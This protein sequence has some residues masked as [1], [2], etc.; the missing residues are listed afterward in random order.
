V[1]NEQGQG[2]VA[3]L[4]SAQHAHPQL[5]FSRVNVTA[6]SQRVKIKRTRWTVHVACDIFLHS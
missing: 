6:L 1:R 3:I 4:L 5:I 2:G